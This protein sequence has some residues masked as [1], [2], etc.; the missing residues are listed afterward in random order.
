MFYYTI[1]GTKFTNYSMLDSV[2]LIITMVGSTDSLSTRDAK[3]S[4]YGRYICAIVSK[5][6]LFWTLHRNELEPCAVCFSGCVINTVVIAQ[7]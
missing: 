2:D 3:S 6:V 5:A 1:I 7:S 4:R